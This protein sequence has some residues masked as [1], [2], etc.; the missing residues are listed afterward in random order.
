MSAPCPAAGT[1]DQ[2]RPFGRGRGPGDPR[3]SRQP[4]GAQ[5]A[6][7]PARVPRRS[8]R[9]DLDVPPR[10]DQPRPGGPDVII[11]DTNVVSEFVK[12][13]P[14]S[15]VLD[16]AQGVDPTDLTICV[17]T[18]EEIERGLGRLP[19]GRRRRDLEQRWGRLVD[20]FSE[21]APST[22]CQQPATPPASS[23]PPKQPTG[24]CP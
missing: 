8:R 18:V 17:V 12:D 20:T 11:A 2:A 16:R 22:T 5:L 21:V 23:W 1:R 10:I 4:P 7:V 19:E 9:V 15:P 14:D 3:R 24:R 13:I 6:A